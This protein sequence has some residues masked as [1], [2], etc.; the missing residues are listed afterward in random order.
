MNNNWYNNIKIAYEI[1][2]FSDRNDMNLRIKNFNKII[3]DIKYWQKLCEQDAPKVQKQIKKL[4]KMKQMSSF[5]KVLQALTV[6]D[7]KILDSRQTCKNAL[8][9]VQ[10]NLIIEVKKMTK[11]RD[12][13][14]KK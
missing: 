9:K 13:W 6:A 10:Q 11:V 4:L 5:P 14:S 3:Q 8:K 12:S 2:N 7:K 1:N